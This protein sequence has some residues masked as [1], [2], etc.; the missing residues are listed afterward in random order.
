[1][2]LRA[3]TIIF[4]NTL[5]SIG[6]CYLNTDEPS[7]KITIIPTSNKKNFE[8]INVK[9][10]NVNSPRFNEDI[11]DDALFKSL[12]YSMTGDD[13]SFVDKAHSY[14]KKLPSD[15][16]EIIIREYTKYIE[17][18]LVI[19]GL[20]AGIASY[21]AFLTLIENGLFN[22]ELPFHINI[23]CSLNNAMT[24]NMFSFLSLSL[25]AAVDSLFSS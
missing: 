4:T 5:T 24:R 23:P 25:T 8:S 1:M 12:I 20:V 18:G 10:S 13:I 21:I 7:L 22:N 11:T 14:M 15:E 19:D 9:Y 16:S 2:D 6:T 3:T 17:N